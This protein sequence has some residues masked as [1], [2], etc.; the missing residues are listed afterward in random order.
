MTLVSGSVNALA[1]QKGWA[2][3]ASG[4]TS[5]VVGCRLVFDLLEAFLERGVVF[6]GVIRQDVCTTSTKTVMPGNVAFV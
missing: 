4:V 1:I 5:M 6:V 2:S 3:L